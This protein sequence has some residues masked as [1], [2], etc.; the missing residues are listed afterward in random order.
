MFALL[1][2]L[3]ESYLP[4][5]E[6][7]DETFESF[8]QE[9]AGGFLLVEESDEGVVRG[10]TLTTVSRLLHTNGPVAQLQE[11]V[12]EESA[13]GK[14][15]GA[16]LVTATEDECR[17]R[18]VRQLTVASRRASGFYERLGYGSTADYL[19]RTFD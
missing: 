4:D 18:G 1:Q 19:K 9:G 12:V 5:R 17:A 16:T 13:R 6:A 8:A 14:R 11:L 3:A 10:Y 2:Q 15:I 7:F